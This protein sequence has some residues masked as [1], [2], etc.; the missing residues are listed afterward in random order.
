MTHE[1]LVRTYSAE[2][3]AL[4]LTMHHA[5]SAEMQELTV[6]LRWD[7]HISPTN[8]ECIRAAHIEQYRLHVDEITRLYVGFSQ[9]VITRDNEPAIRVYRNIAAQ[10][11][12]AIDRNP[13]A[14]LVKHMETG[15]E[16]FAPYV[17]WDRDWV[18]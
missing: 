4:E 17:E 10:M 12:H 15:E 16:M 18:C 13:N 9:L 8:I 1:H 3:E 7:G 6:D 11:L 2:F 14:I 5:M